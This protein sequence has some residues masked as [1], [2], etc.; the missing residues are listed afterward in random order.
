[1]AVSMKIDIQ[2]DA[3][4]TITIDGSHADN[5]EKSSGS[6]GNSNL[7]LETEGKGSGQKQH[8]VSPLAKISHNFVK[9]PLKYFSPTVSKQKAISD[10]A[11]E[12]SKSM[13]VYI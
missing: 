9:E 12:M 8:V 3:L 13:Y 5:R 7:K 11:S 2:S 6:S 4:S 10:M 1:M